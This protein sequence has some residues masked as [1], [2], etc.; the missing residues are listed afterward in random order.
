MR[1]EVSLEGDGLGLGSESHGGFDPPGS[2]LARVGD[3]PR[4]VSL[5][6]GLQVLSKADVISLWLRQAWQHVDVE[7]WFVHDKP[8]C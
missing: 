8:A 2:E 6:S 4:I 7:E 5:Q 3:I 1:L